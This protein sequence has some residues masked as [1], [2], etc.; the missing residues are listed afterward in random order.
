MT[1]RPSRSATALAA[2]LAL[3]AVLA[4]LCLAAPAPARDGDGDGGGGDDEAR[5]SG[6]CSRGATSQLRL[7]ARDDGTIRVEFDV[8]RRRSGEAWRVVII[9]ERRVAARASARTSGSS[10]SFR[11]R[12]S[13][14][15][16]DGPDRVTV[17][18]SGPG[19]RTCEATAMLASAR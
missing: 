13:L 1:L 10:G 8:R 3:G 14:T 4:L 16:L 11:V 15:D 6:H 2:V 5:V 9:H 12:R 19:G 7:R 17:R 18:G